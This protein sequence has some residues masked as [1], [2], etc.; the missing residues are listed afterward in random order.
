MVL[1]PANG[2][3]HGLKYVVP[4]GAVDVA[5]VV[6]L[7]VDTAPTADGNIGIT[8]P[9]LPAIPVAV[10]G[11]AV[12]EI[13]TCIITAGATADTTVG[14]V[15]PSLPQ[16]DI[17]VTNGMTTAQVA[18]AIQAGTYTGWTATIGGT[19]STVLFTK[20]DAGAVP[21]AAGLFVGTS[22]VDGSITS[23]T[24]GEDADTVEAVALKIESETFTGWTPVATGDTVVF[25]RDTAGVVAGSPAFEDTDTTGTEATISITTLGADNSVTFDF[26]SGGSYPYGLAAVVTVKNT[27]GTDAT[28]TGFAVTYP[29]DGVV[30]VN[31]SL[32]A[33]TI[34]TLVAQRN[35]AV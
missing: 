24:A 12:A 34:I 35:C 22:G 13:V 6:T 26:R 17:T 14:I 28:P 29:A 16:V 10:Q 27:D 25:T 32:V 15:L 2:V 9:S 30:Q 5:E 33:G 4:S 23:T 1:R 20:D 8:L 18:D 7:V 3:S 21:G 19:A 11:V 31:G